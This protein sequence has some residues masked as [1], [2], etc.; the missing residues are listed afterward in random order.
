MTCG[1]YTGASRKATAGRCRTYSCK[2]EGPDEDGNLVDVFES[3]LLHPPGNGSVEDGLSRDSFKVGDRITWQGP[4][5]KNPRAGITRAWLWAESADG[6][7]LP[8]MDPDRRI[9]ETCRKA[10]WCHRRTLP[11]LWKRPEISKGLQAAL[12]AT[13][14]LANVGIQDRNHD[15][16]LRRRPVTRWSPVAIQGPPKMP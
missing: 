11:A 3:R 5:D 9:S 15:R 13:G 6:K 16:Q 1:L 2:V 4:H 10:K 12:H 7:R 8:G 14:R